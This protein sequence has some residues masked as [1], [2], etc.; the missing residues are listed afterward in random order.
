MPSPPK[1]VPDRHYDF[2][3]MNIVFAWSSIGLLAVT[4]W[5]VFDDYAK[6]WK[7]VQAEFRSLER[8]K[9][10]AEEEGERGRLNQE[11]LAG[12]QQQLA[13]EQASLDSQKG[14][15][16]DLESQI[17]AMEKKVY[18]SDAV[19]RT[20]KSKLDTARYGLDAATQQ[21][22]PDAVAAAREHFEALS[23]QYRENRKTLE[24]YT[25]TRDEL[26]QELAAKR[27]GLTEAQAS[28]AGLEANVDALQK[29]I[30]GLGNKFSY[31][32]L[33]APLMDF[34]QPDL[35]IEQVILPGLYQ[36]IHFTTVE[37]VDR[38]MTC[39]VAATRSGFTGEEWEEPYRTHPRLDLF[40][41]ASSPHPYTEFGC[42]A[43]HGG[44]DRATDFARA[45]HSPANEEQ[46]AEWERKWDWEAQ[47]YLENPIL[48]ASMTEAGCIT[49]HAGNV[50]TPASE[51]QDVGRELITRMGCYGCHQIDYA[52]F[53]DLG[54]PGPG[55]AKVASKT[56][57]GWAYKWIEAPREFRPTTWMPHFFFQENIQGD[58]NKERQR[59]EIASLVAYL[60]D[61]SEENTYPTPP[62][63]SA[64]QG[65]ALFDSVG[66]AGCH[67]IDANA[68]RDEFYPQFNR[69]NGPNLVRTGSKVNAGW[70]Y[71]WIKDP[72][73]YHPTT[74]MPRLRLTD[75]EA[76]DLVAFLMSQRDPA[77]EG[78]EVPQI[79]GQVRDDLVLGYLQESE[80]IE[81]SQASLAAMS[82][83]ERDV[84]LGERTVRKYGCYACHDVEGFAGAKPIG[85]EL[86]E[87]GS[88]PLHQF[89][90]GHV[91]D[92]PHTRHDWIRNKLLDPRQWDEGKALVKEYHELYKMPNFGMSE[93]E[94]EAV[95]VNVLGFTKESVLASRKADQDP[96]SATL[97]DGRRMIT[98]YNCQGCHLIEG[99][100]HAIASALG[101]V[102]LLPPNL[103]SEGARVQAGW[104][105]RYLHDPGSVRM[106]PWLG[107]RMPTFGFDD[108]QIN[109]LIGYFTARDG[110]EPFLSAATRPD[111]RSLA[112]GRTTFNML[113]CAKCHPAGPEAAAG[114]VANVGELAPSLLLARDRLRHDWVPG[115]IKDPQSWVPGTKMP[116]N[117]V[118][119]T[120]GSYDSPLANAIEAPM[121][122]DQKN[123]MLRQFGS[124]E[125]LKA[126]LADADNVT[127][128]LRDH[129]WWNL[130]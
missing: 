103:A 54:K 63:G 23:Q 36:D 92:V 107:V 12:V 2:R 50:W 95:L 37:R 98:W 33:N 24:G 27:A 30:D 74:R 118:H 102:D 127:T 79:D 49:C 90:F 93:R 28:L 75:D 57:P 125:E 42:T 83:S 101:D 19:A 100:G 110:R 124:E 32:M 43:C 47:K 52:S 128:A 123:Q 5:M 119:R 94:A 8:Q 58:L 55:L 16:G 29:R 78:L 96:L 65:K 82:A 38:C 6:P 64:S 51:V 22:D 104:L 56:T 73:Q 77:Y 4:L 129:I 109:T 59:A 46:K 111:E 120:D 3:G 130:R 45:G 9:L 121:F 97:A 106:R 35:K 105:F 14:E 122:A 44:L 60:W 126:F 15:I 71:A 114:G 72:K 61:H 21:G 70:L 11:E 87:E 99:K 89:D 62:A 10:L 81:Q 13:T 20:T 66:C 18:A 86:T 108:D 41:S 34:V 84:F 26:Q 17:S 112:V 1:K 115:W 91:H 67:L 31:F 68:K 7:R 53:R 113:Q 48:P 85:V 117:F 39:H 69:M 40:V 88:K 116:A 80:T 25:E 76:A